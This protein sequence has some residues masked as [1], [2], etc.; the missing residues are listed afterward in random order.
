MQNV[1]QEK[2]HIVVASSI[3][4]ILWIVSSLFLIHGINADSISYFSIS[5]KYFDGNFSEA[6]N[7]YWGP[8]FSWLIIPAFLIKIEPHI[9]A[10]IL[11]GIFSVALFFLVDKY[12]IR[13]ELNKN[14]RSLGIYFFVL[15]ALF[16]SFYRLTPDYLLLIITLAYV[17]VVSDKNYW[18]K[19]N[20]VIISSILGAIMFLTKSYGLIFFIVYQTILVLMEH[21][22]SKRI[23]RN[24][25]L[26][27]FLSLVVLS[28]FISPWIF[29]LSNKYG[30]FT[31]STSGAINIRIVN[32]ELNFKHPPIESGF[33]EP[34]DQYSISAWDDP[35]LE[36]YPEWNPLSFSNIKYF[37]TNTAK[38]VLK[39]IIFILAFSPLLSSLIIFIRKKEIEN[40]ILVKILFAGI[41]YGLGYTTIYVENRYIWPSCVLITIIGVFILNSFYEKIFTN[42]LK[43]AVISF[44]III[45]F[46][47]FFIYGI[48][49]QLPNTKAYYQAKSLKNNLEI[50]G[51]I[52]STNY[53]DHGLALSYFLNSK[54]Y[55][56]EKLPLN[57]PELLEKAKK[58]GINYIFDYSNNAQSPNGLKFIGKIDS[59]SVYKIVEQTP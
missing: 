27:Y 41:I 29:L 16:F 59:I 4:L 58:M 9:F 50:S 22:S 55:G 25:L 2:K 44:L 35:D 5:K 23:S 15:P 33:A 8:L 34:S 32:P 48:T 24:I 52:A 3:Y 18:E 54:F 26:N 56:T 51:N 7:A 57:K 30:A 14:I 53:W 39:L 43:S 37:L 46:I 19:K 12:L 13:F 40:K 38:N 20:Q 21:Y 31:V 17:Y 6:I 1:L 10:R 28:I 42:S 49:Q 11:F 36:A 45:S 47:P